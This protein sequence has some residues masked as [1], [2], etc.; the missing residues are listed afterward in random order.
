MIRET[1]YNNIRACTGP[2]IGCF[3]T[4][5]WHDGVIWDRS[6]PTVH[7]AGQ[8]WTWETKRQA[9][10]DKYKDLVITPRA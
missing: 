7:F 1:N 5:I 4:E 10:L 6:M 8:Q 2:E 9:Y 3:A